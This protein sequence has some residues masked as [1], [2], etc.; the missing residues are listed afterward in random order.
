MDYYLLRNEVV[1]IEQFYEYVT[2]VLSGTD[3]KQIEC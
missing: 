3:K 2:S 1:F